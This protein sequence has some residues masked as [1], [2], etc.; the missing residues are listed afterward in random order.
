MQSIEDSKDKIHNKPL[1]E[2]VKELKIDL[3]FSDQPFIMG[4]CATDENN[5]D[6]VI[7]DIVMPNISGVGIIA[8]LKK[9]YPKIIVVAITGW[10]EHPE[11]LASEAQADLVLEKP[12]DLI[13]LDKIIVDFIAEKEKQVKENET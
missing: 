6:V 13:K 2:L 4:Y 9:K 7:T 5:F 10:G 11:V 3:N 1:S 8:I 12:I